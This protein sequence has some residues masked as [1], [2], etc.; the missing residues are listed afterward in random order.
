MFA[1]WASAE[2]LEIN[3]RDMGVNSIAH[4]IGTRSGDAAIDAVIAALESGDS[5]AIARL[6]RFETVGCT[7]E[8]GLGGPPKCG[9]DDAEGTMVEALA[10]GGCEG[11]W[12]LEPELQ[13]TEGLSRFVKAYAG[14]GLYAVYRLPASAERWPKGESII[15]F[16][17]DTGFGRFAQTMG[18][19]GGRIVSNWGGCGTQPE[20]ILMGAEGATVILAPPQ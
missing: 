20:K 18:V 15:V 12:W 2:F 8:L 11:G 4:P 14:A 7:H 13:S 10:T 17:R 1:G 3:G 5:Q 16:V 19:T 6:L 9:Q